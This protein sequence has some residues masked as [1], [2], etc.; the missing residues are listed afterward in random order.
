MHA[1]YSTRAHTIYYN[2]EAFV[3]KFVSA[4]TVT[5]ILRYNAYVHEQ[6]RVH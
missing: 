3:S 2:G 4:F 1:G 6:P 5:M